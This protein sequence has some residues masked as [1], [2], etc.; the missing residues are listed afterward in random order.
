M[1]WSSYARDLQAEWAG[2]LASNPAEKGI[3]EFLERHPSMVPGA[4]SALGRLSSGHGPFPHA[5]ISQPPL[6]ALGGRTPDFVWLSRDSSFFNPVF[7]EIED[8]AKPWVTRKGVPRAELTQALDQ[9]RRWREW[10]DVPSNRQTFLDHFQVPLMFRKRKFQPI[11]VLIYGRHDT[12]SDEV[13]KLR[14]SLTAHDQYVIP[15]DHL[16]PDPAAADFL[17]VKNARGTYQ[18]VTFPATATMGPA[19]ASSWALVHGLPKAIKRNPQ[20]TP[21]RKRFLIKRLDYWNEYA[22]DDGGIFRPRDRE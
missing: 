22:R 14:A 1:S 18:A 13:N 12:R 21:E 9:L 4:F 16:K 20:I 11:F 15:Y 6:K 3:Q 7:I 2:L 8:P 17:C 10:L 5:L 19:T